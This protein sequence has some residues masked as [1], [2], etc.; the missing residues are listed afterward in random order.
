MKTRGL[1]IELQPL[2]NS[3]LANL[4]GALDENLRQIEMAYDVT[5]T[6]RGAH[7]R[8]DGDAAPARLAA[9]ALKHFYVHAQAPLSIDDIQLGLVELR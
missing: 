1:S 7:C 6:R 2:D 3:R 8:I 4:C 9:A 5:L